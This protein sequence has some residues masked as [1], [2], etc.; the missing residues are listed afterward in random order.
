MPT[1]IRNYVPRHAGTQKDLLVR[2]RIVFLRIDAGQDDGEPVQLKRKALMEH[3]EALTPGKDGERRWEREANDVVTCEIRSKEPPQQLVLRKARFDEQP[4]KLLAD[5]T[6]EEV[7]LAEDELLAEYT[8]LT[9]FRNNIV[10]AV[11]NSHG[12]SPRVLEGYLAAKAA[13]VCPF[14]AVRNLLRPE[15]STLLRTYGKLPL[16]RVRLRKSQLEVADELDDDVFSAIKTVMDV[17]EPDDIE[18]VFRE[19]RNSKHGIGTKLLQWVRRL[20][21]RDDVERLVDRLEVKGINPDTDKTDETLNLLDAKFTVITDIKRRGT[22][23]RAPDEVDAF[24]AISHVYDKY[25]DA[26]EGAESLE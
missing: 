3:L 14:V 1:P 4:Q 18:V 22:R 6:V 13:D 17:G 23:S 26:I 7:E 16:L 15:I 19:Q 8:Y 12:P 5:D 20:I 10:A 24:E 25:Q 11:Q 9:F 2:K 21:G